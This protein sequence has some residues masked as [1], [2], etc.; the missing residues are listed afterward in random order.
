MQQDLEAIGMEKTNIKFTIPAQSPPT[1]I[2]EVDFAFI[3]QRI[4]KISSN[5]DSQQISPASQQKRNN[6][7]ITIELLRPKPK[8][9]I[10]LQAVINLNIPF[11]TVNDLFHLAQKFPKFPL[12]HHTFIQIFALGSIITLPGMEKR[13]RIAPCLSFSKHGRIIQLLLVECGFRRFDY[14][15]YIT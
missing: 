12:H 15:P 14:I 7:F 5:P 10:P 11:I 13:G 9:H 3:D 6:D 4:Y 1:F 2:K 8:Q